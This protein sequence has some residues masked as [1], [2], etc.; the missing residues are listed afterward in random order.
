[1]ALLEIQ[2]SCF[3]V[4]YSDFIHKADA[5]RSSSRL[6]DISSSASRLRS[7]HPEAGIDSW[8]LFILLAAFSATHRV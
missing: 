5:T 1:M 4:F 3:A 8:H 6:Q 7:L 2:T